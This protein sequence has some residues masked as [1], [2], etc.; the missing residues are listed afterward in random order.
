MPERDLRISSRF[1]VSN[2]VVLVTG[3]ATGLGEMAAQVFVQSKARLIIAG[4]KESVLKKTTDRLD[5][6]V[7]GT[8]E[9]IVAHLKDQAGCD[10]F[11]NEAKK[12]ADRLTVLA[13]TG[14]TW[15]APYDNFP[16]TE[17]E[18][19][20]ALNVKSV[21]YMT[22]ALQNH[23]P[24]FRARQ[25]KLKEAILIQATS[26]PSDSVTNNYNIHAEFNRLRNLTCTKAIV[27]LRLL[28]RRRIVTISTCKP[29]FIYDTLPKLD[30]I[31][32]RWK[33]SFTT[34][35]RSSE[36]LIVWATGLATTSSSFRQ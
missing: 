31:T 15:G 27:V 3:G 1:D 4:R 14:A 18:K 13:D 2:H 7:P 11:I 20:M 5:S 17:W 29:T 35:N 36:H 22:V 10:H 30:C 33:S 28:A 21:F 23:Q 24:T 25:T 16:E 6:P 19:V 8:C 32:S 34:N 9:Y 12:R 26:Y